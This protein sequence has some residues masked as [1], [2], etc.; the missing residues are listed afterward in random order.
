MGQPSSTI[1][2]EISNKRSVE[3]DYRVPENETLTDLVVGLV[4]AVFLIGVVTALRSRTINIPLTG[5]ALLKKHS[6][7]VFNDWLDRLHNLGD[8]R[9]FVRTL[10]ENI[11]DLGMKCAS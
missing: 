4:A 5:S 11:P 6:K 3:I 2:D 10:R 7:G 8:T 9:R 1:T